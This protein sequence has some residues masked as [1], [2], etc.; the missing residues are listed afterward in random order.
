MCPQGIVPH[1]SRAA[2]SAELAARARDLRGPAGER[3]ETVAATPRELYGTDRCNGLPPDLTVYWDRLRLRSAG[4]VGHGALF[5]PGN[6]TGPDDANHD[7]HGIF[8]VAGGRAPRTGRIEGLRV[9]YVF[10]T[11][12]ALLRIETPAGV[13]GRSIL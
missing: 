4:T 10:S 1:A 2:E 12:A 9:E 11:V 8:A 7:F 5:L 6:D 3:L 13:A